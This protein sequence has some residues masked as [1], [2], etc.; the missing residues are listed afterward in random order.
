M[1]PIITPYVIALDPGKKTG[2]AI[3]DKANDVISA[4]GEDQF[5][6]TCRW[7]EHYLSHLGPHCTV[8]TERFLITVRTARNSQAPWSLEMIGVARWLSLKYGVPEFKLQDVAA[9]K[10]FSSNEHLR[11][12]GWWQVGSEGHVNDALRHMLLFLVSRGWWSDK[13]VIDKP[14]EIAE[15]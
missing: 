15:G 14:A 12:L 3:Y 13:L 2:F 1:P 11:E 9:A 8:I 6:A 5:D 4:C 10:R 7:L